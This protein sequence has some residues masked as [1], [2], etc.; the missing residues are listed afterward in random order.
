MKN[1]SS[2]KPSVCSFPEKAEQIRV[3]ELIQNLLS[4]FTVKAESIKLFPDRPNDNSVLTR[5]EFPEENLTIIINP[6]HRDLSLAE[7]ASTYGQNQST[8][9][10][11][12]IV[13]GMNTDGRSYV[14]TIENNKPSL[15]FQDKY[16]GFTV[17]DISSIYDQVTSETDLLKIELEKLSQ[18]NQKRDVSQIKN[19]VLTIDHHHRNDTPEISSAANQNDQFMQDAHQD[20]PE[21]LQG[22][23][24]KEW[25][26]G[27][28]KLNVII[29]DSDT[30]NLTYLAQVFYIILIKRYKATP[31]T[32][33]IS[34]L[35]SLSKI[36]KN[37][38][39]IIPV[40]FIRDAC[41]GGVMPSDYPEALGNLSDADYE[42]IVRQ[43]YYINLNHLLSKQKFTLRE[44]QTVF[45][46]LTEGL[47]RMVKLFLGDK[48][49]YEFSEDLRKYKF[50]SKLNQFESK[51]EILTKEQ[52]NQ[53]QPA[54]VQLVGFSPG[55][56][57]WINQIPC[58]ITIIDLNEKSNHPS[59]KLP[60]N[61]G[62]DSTPLPYPYRYT[63]SAKY[64]MLKRDGKEKMLNYIG[65]TLNQ[66]EEMLTGYPST[67]GIRP[68]IGGNRNAPHGSKLNPTNIY[69]SIQHIISS[70][71]ANYQ[72]E[73][74]SPKNLAEEIYNQV[75]DG[76]TEE[77]I[78]QNDGKDSKLIIRTVPQPGDS[79]PNLYHV[80]WISD[81]LQPDLVKASFT[82][83]SED[84]LQTLIEILQ[85]G[86]TP[87]ETIEPSLNLPDMRSLMKVI[88]STQLSL[89]EQL[90]RD[91]M[92]NIAA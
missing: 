56:Y 41:G 4:D 90:L 29:C 80:T 83:A 91:A 54:K 45:Q 63:I 11:T 58:Y 84:H 33:K 71:E 57:H 70:F 18:R 68:A 53:L 81:I 7:L 59:T 87:V 82:V 88:E 32:Q 55:V 6:H 85:N 20:K 48:Q 64:F 16:T 26:E 65:D 3:P 77:R 17:H 24:L 50:N 74:L 92:S 76:I 37:Y 40:E 78:I 86:T 23:I 60:K 28:R 12:T 46:N 38:K 1:L 13:D 43:L 19:F 61:G 8:P 36:L 21:T 27:K 2:Q 72:N 69:K 34:F 42:T 62:L 25:I 31:P 10:V 47:N 15:V 5:I 51:P 39:K 52:I 49:E 66:L 30:D 89:V 14:M 9:S 35:R 67:F 22:Q 44:G 73:L 75:L 79:T